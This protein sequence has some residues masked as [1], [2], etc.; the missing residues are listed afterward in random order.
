MPDLSMPDQR[1]DV[2]LFPIVRIKVV[3]IS[4]PT[5]QRAIEVALQR[6]PLEQLEAAL[7]P[8]EA[9]FAEEY[10]HFLVD[11]VGDTEFEH[12]QFFYSSADPGLSPLRRL[13]AWA[14]GRRDI[15][16]LKQIVAEARETLR[17]CL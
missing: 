11:V 5:P 4:A 13:V 15:A 10:S 16:V 12:S 2:H 6:A 14:D 1:F 3:D 17:F 8:L 9:E 7:K